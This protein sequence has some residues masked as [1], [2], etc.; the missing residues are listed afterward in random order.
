[1]VAGLQAPW[2]GLHLRRGNSLIGA[3]KAVFTRDAGRGQVLAE[4][5]AEAG[6]AGLRTSPTTRVRRPDPPLP[7]AGRR[8]GRRG[9]RART[10]R[11]S[12]PSGR[13]TSRTGA[14][15]CGP[16]RPRS[17]STSWRHGPARRD[18]VGVR[19]RRLEIADAADPPR[20]RPIWGA[21]VARDRQPSGAVSR[22]RRSRRRSPTRR[23]LP[24]AAP[25]HGRLVRAVVLAAHRG[26]EIASRRRLRA[27]DRRAATILGRHA[28]KVGKRAATRRSAGALDW[29]ELDSA[30][31]TRPRLR[32]RLA[33][34][35]R[36]RGITPG[37][38]VCERIAERQGFFHW[39]LDF[40]PVFD[41]WRLRPPGRQPAV[42]AAA[43]RRRRAA[44]R[45]RPVVA[46]RCASR[47]T[48]AGGQ[49][50]DRDPRS[51]PG[52]GTR[53]RRNR[54]TSRARRDSWAHARSTRICRAYSRISTAASWSR[55][56]EHSVTHGIIGPDPS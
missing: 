28:R 41:T 40:A 29:D 35:G 23:R 48:E 6:R 34:R 46:T 15:R 25:G 53:D 32:R 42:G 14:G 21:D 54:A 18:A 27:V 22:A 20:H 33:D 43:H 55:P 26:R 24:A 31:D 44:R 8:L 13:A 47:P 10:S 45:G 11:S 17:R 4:G 1:M 19:T 12:R 5:G 50:D 52:S 39:E 30:E 51:C 2:F 38:T 7:A 16:S 9:R 37:S 36:A 56:G 49:R 3:R